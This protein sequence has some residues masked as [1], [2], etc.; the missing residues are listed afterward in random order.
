LQQVG[1]NYL[2]LNRS[3]RSLSGGESQRIRL[4]TQIGSKLVN[5]LYILDEPS[6]GLHQRDNVK[7]INSL[8][9]L[10]DEGNSVMVVE[11]D[12]EMIRECDWLIDL[13]P[14]A[15]VHGGKLLFSGTADELYKM[16]VNKVKTLNSYT[17]DYI[18]GLKKIEIPLE[19][20]KGNGLFLELKGAI[21][22]NLKGVDLKIPL[23]C[24]VG[25][26]GL[27]EVENPHL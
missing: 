27:V 6:I 8:K 13:G 18:R 22:N 26:S 23:G 24:F 16:P 5:V 21:G 3:T 15:G 19:R 1:L 25:V 2:S 9:R 10:R 14:Q 20:R 4:A 11:H 12:E 7:L 17:A